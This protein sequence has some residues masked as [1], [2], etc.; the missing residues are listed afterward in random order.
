MSWAVVKTE[1][2]L[3]SSVPRLRM[4]GREGERRGGQGRVRGGE[5][6]GKE[7]KRWEGKGEGSE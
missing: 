1:Y 7:A 4:E 3:L 2:E 6:V 5:V